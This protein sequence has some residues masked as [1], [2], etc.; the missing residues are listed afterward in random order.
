MLL[1]VKLICDRRPRKD[2]TN[3]ICIQ[4]CFRADKRT[5]LNTEVYIPA[6]YWNK[7]LVRIAKEIPA[8]YGNAEVLN[9]ALCRQMRI[10][11]DI[12]SF[13]KR[14]KIDDPLSFLKKTFQ[15]NFDIAFLE[16]LSNEP[17]LLKETSCNKKK[18]DLYS[19]IDVT[20]NPRKEKSVKT[21]RGFTET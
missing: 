5:I 2:R 11:E 17:D 21:C 12:I 20:F 10:V 8:T 9:E 15:P 6:R 18:L 13:A 1:P 19:Q 3:P 14:K 7:K 16:N 4:Y